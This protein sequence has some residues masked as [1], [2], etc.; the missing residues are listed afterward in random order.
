MFCVKCG[1]E[2]SDADAYCGRCGQKTVSVSSTPSEGVEA[3]PLMRPPLDKPAAR[4]LSAEEIASENA[5]YRRRGVYWLVAPVVSLIAI[6]LVYAIAS[7]LMGASGDSESTA[8]GVVRAALGLL[9]IISVL[10]IFVGVPL[11]IVNLCRRE[12]VSP[13]LRGGKGGGDFQVASVGTRLCN[14]M[15]DYVGMLIFILGLSALVSLLLNDRIK[16]A[17]SGLLALLCMPIYYMFFEGIWQRTPG[18]WLTRTKV[19]TEAGNKPT[20][21]NIVGRSFARIIPFEPFSFLGGPIGWHDSLSGTLVV[22]V[23]YSAEDVRQIDTVAAKGARKSTAVIVVA[24]V[25]VVIAVIGLLSTL[26]VVALNSARQKARDSKRVADI[27]Q[28]QTALELYF[29]DN[30]SY[31]VVNGLEGLELGSENGAIL[32]AHGFGDYSSPVYMNSVP[33]APTPADGG[34]TSAENSYTYS[35]IDGSNYSLSFCLGGSVGTLTAGTH[36]ASQ[37]GIE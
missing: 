13:H 11:G 34:C 2:L 6:M 32:A 3:T 25:V 9:G 26:A 22:P 16:D 35:S 15:I 24:V 5:K 21:L 23:K 10:G 4:I 7:F 33:A 8:M 17:V 31:P 1:H 37:S 27:K 18:K 28:I 20:F 29:A 36:R 19:V 30:N 12:T 14:Y